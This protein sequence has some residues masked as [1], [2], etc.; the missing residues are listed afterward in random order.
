MQMQS[1]PYVPL[2]RTCAEITSLVNLL[3][4][5]TTDAVVAHTV[6]AQLDAQMGRLEMH[7]ADVRAQQAAVPLSMA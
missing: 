7:L 3:S 1:T 2:S 5:S 4:A 6:K